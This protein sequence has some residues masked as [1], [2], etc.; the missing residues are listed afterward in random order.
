[1]D[2]TPEP[3][4]ASSV[5]A[6]TPALATTAASRVSTTPQAAATA[7]SVLGFDPTGSAPTSTSETTA[8]GAN[9]LT[10]TPAPPV[11]A[12]EEEE[13]E[14]GSG[15][16]A[17]EV[18]LNG[19]TSD[20]DPDNDNDIDDEDDS[21]TGSTP[22]SSIVDAPDGMAPLPSG[23]PPS[24]L[25]HKYHRHMAR[26]AA[27]R[28]SVQALPS[29][30]DLQLQFSGGGARVEH[31]AGLGVGIRSSP[32]A[33]MLEDDEG[34]GRRDRT[35][36][37]R[38]WKEVQLARV[39]AVEASAEA[40][41]LVATIRKRWGPGR[42]SPPSSPG[43]PPEDVRGAFVET[44]RAVRRVRTLALALVPSG[45]RR[46]SGPAGRSGVP[47]FSTPSRP[48][49][50]ATRRVVSG[51][52]DGRSGSVP[53]PVVATPDPI[54]PVRRAALD[55]LGQLRHLEERIRQQH[56]KP[57]KLVVI[58][59]GGGDPTVVESP[60]AVTHQH[61]AD[62]TTSPP[63]RSDNSSPAFDSPRR[64]PNRRLSSPSKELLYSPAS[65]N[66]DLA[67]DDF[68]DNEEYF[69]VNDLAR[70]LENEDRPREPWEDRLVSEDRRYKTV[71]P[72]AWSAESRK[73]SEA[74]GRWADAVERAFGG[75]RA[76]GPTGAWA[77]DP[78]VTELERARA[79]IAAHLTEEHVKLLPPP[80]DAS[81]LL[82]RLSD[83][84]LLIQAFNSHVLASKRPWGDIPDE[85]IHETVTSAPQGDAAR[86]WT[87]RLIGNLTP[88]AAALRHRYNLPLVMP[89][90][91]SSVLPPAEKKTSPRRGVQP[92]I[93]PLRR[94]DIPQIDFDPS[95][96]AKK[97]EGWE[98]MLSALLFAWVSEAAHEAGGARTVSA[99][100]SST[101]STPPT[102]IETPGEAA[103]PAAAGE[104]G[105]G[106]AQ[107]D[108]PTTTTTT[109]TS[110]ET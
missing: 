7:P 41:Q 87:F 90:T 61:S 86:E 59:D 2:P 22:G 25:R 85:D 97:S 109:T 55:L 4:A 88:W 70:E 13:S 44:A 102:I 45:Q 80:S 96:V 74:A 108:A 18:R 35:Q 64:Y 78:N 21:F 83:G 75:E 76:A 107:A 3:S 58:P 63:S 11:A 31:R 100:L 52:S 110:D 42:G 79:F 29:I 51:A 73:V 10:R 95:V 77:S 54:A 94:R 34:E 53:P 37:P 72:T 40:T 6:S 65:S 17:Y 56:D 14:R 27:K 60:V 50:K 8:I 46:V 99:A 30:R 39:N 28:E 57:P 23:P 103:E 9:R 19:A 98:G 38:P 26:S 81:A 48:A 69:N 5:E 101:P 49:V 68:S 15:V 105:D 20:F 92:S 66:G 36:E 1:M 47:T 71:S 84:Y 43:A 32:L 12:I 24:G 67:Y 106:K 89:A 62:T 93:P 91:P 16:T 104:A 82:G 33:A